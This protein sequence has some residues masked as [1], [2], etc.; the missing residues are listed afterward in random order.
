MYC[1][2]SRSHWITS[3]QATQAVHAGAGAA[4]LRPERGVGGVGAAQTR[5]RHAALLLRAAQE[6]QTA[7]QGAWLPD[8]YSQIYWL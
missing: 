8:G 3:T 6:R 2:F 4:A 7:D 1:D 5:A